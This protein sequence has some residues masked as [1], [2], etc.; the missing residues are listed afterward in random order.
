VHREFPP[1]VRLPNEAPLPEEPHRQAAKP[2]PVDDD[3]DLF[4]VERTAAR[5]SELIAVVRPAPVRLGA[6]GQPLL[7]PPFVPNHDRFEGPPWADVTLVVFGAHGT[8]AARPLGRILDSVRERLGTEVRV[9]WRHHPDP[10]AHPRAPVFALAAEAA[11][12]LGHFWVLTRELLRMRH[13]DPADLHAAMLRAGV[14]PERALA[15]MRAGVGT[16]RI[17]EDVASALASGVSYS[18]ALF[19]NGERYVGELDRAA[20]WSALEEA[21]RGA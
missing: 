2:L 13:D 14:D 9:A 3:V 17:A 7:S 21:R 11:V 10:R 8:P 16:E 4:G 18:P 1:P 5:L 15:A 19:I 20:V 12:S 6:Y